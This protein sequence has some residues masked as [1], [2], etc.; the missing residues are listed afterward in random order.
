MTTSRDARRLRAFIKRN[1]ESTV[2]VQSAVYGKDGLHRYTATGALIGTKGFVLTTYGAVAHAESVTATYRLVAQ[3]G[4]VTTY[5][6][7]P[8]ELTSFSREYDVA[9]LRLT[10]QDQ[11]QAPFPLRHGPVVNGDDYWW[12]GVS[13]GARKMVVKERNIT[14]SLNGQSF[15][16][17]NGTLGPSDNGAP[18]VNDC[19][20]FVGIL[21]YNDTKGVYALPLETIFPVLN[22]RT[23]DLY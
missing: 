19:G 7:T 11:H 21:L 14:M 20:E 4:E 13:S 16:L 5:R 23:T 18:L 17:M 22:L 1:T 9:L 3:N 10:K 8:L 12:F 15:L 2:V 6:E